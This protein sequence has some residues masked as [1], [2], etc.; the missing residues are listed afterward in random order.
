MF[1]AF[2][3][4][5]QAQNL[6]D[7]SDW[8]IGTGSA[9]V[10]SQ[11]GSTSENTREWG[12]GPLGNRVILWKAS[13]DA[14]SNADGGWATDQFAIDHTKMYRFS[15]WIKKTNSNAGTTYFGCNAYPSPVTSL[16][17]TGNT[18]PYFWNGDLPEL[19][20]WYLIVGY[21]HGSG[22]NSTTNYGRIY[23][24]ETGKE[25]LSITDFK[26]QTTATTARHRSYLYYDTNTSDRQ[27]FYA[28][29]MEV[30][31]GNESIADLLGLPLQWLGLQA[32]NL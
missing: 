8:T 7:L 23:D 28:P 21:I 3:F 1:L 29:R 32:Q 25:V 6:L 20:K 2:G 27:Y 5:L 13:P 4:S 14:L 16:T 19:D 18:N 17:G 15:V 31:N 26:F 12:T 30:V 22:D 24:G 11:N 9:G 10:L